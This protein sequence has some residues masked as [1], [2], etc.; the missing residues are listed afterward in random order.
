[1]KRTPLKRTPMKR[2]HKRL[3]ADEKRAYADA[4]ERANGRC[5]I[6]VPGICNGRAEHRH[7]VKLRSRLGKTIAANIKVC[8]NDCH[9]FVHHNPEWATDR[10]FMESAYGEAS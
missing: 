6:Q 4:T 10:A 9:T 1:M 3:T 2:T 8:C 7:H 5:E